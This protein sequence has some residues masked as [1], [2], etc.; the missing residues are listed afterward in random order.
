M[1]SET[2]FVLEIKAL[3]SQMG[4]DPRNAYQISNVCNF[5]AIHPIRDRNGAFERSIAI[6]SNAPSFSKIVEV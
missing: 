5:Y 2:K 3:T 1:R 4:P 6:L